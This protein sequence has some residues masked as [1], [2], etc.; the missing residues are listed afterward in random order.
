MM[1]IPRFLNKGDLIGITCPSGFL[2][3]ENTVNAQKVLEEKGFRV[4]QSCTVGAGDFYFAGSDRLRLE[5]LQYQLDHPEFKAILMGRGG[6][7]LSRI[8]DQLD[9]TKF[10]ADPKWII[11]FSDITVLHSHL[12]QYY[13]IASIH[14][15]MCNS[16][17]YGNEISQPIE[18]L[19][20]LLKGKPSNQLPLVSN[21]FNR[22]GLANGELVGGNLAIL[23]HLTGSES[24]LNCQD[25]IL[26]IEDVGEYL[27]NVDRMLVQLKRAGCFK[28]IKGLICGGF[29]DSKDTERPFGK[30]I[31]EIISS[32]FKDENIPICFDFPAGHIDENYPLILGANY[33]LSVDENQMP[34]LEM[35]NEKKY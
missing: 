29:T 32:H 34:Q 10:L 14:G 24:Q 7:G 33:H 21:T 3:R 1:Q 17:S 6:Y 12:Q 35:V 30:H 28:G 31:Y 11:G 25:R 22:P 26:F 27:Y 23:A 16:F 13:S 2:N 9:F 18:N 8:I 20:Q 15:P 19:I 5:E 4:V